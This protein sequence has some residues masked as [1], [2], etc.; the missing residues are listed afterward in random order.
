MQKSYDKI[1]DRVSSMN[2]ATIN[3]NRLEKELEKTKQQQNR[4]A[5]ELVEYEKEQADTVKMFNKDLNAE[6]LLQQKI[7]NKEL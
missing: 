1:A 2:K 3:T 4:A 7:N 5:R 6:L